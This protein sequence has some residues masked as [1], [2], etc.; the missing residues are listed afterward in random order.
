M[1]RSAIFAAGFAVIAIAGTGPPALAQADDPSFPTYDPAETC[2]G[3]R[4]SDA[5]RNMQ[6]LGRIMALSFWDKTTPAMHADCLATYPGHD[7]LP[8]S[9]CLNHYVKVSQPTACRDLSHE[10]VVYALND[11]LRYSQKP[12][13]VFDVI[14]PIVDG[15]ENGN[16]H[17]NCAATLVSTIGHIRW[18]LYTE[19]INGQIYYKGVSATMAR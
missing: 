15:P 14:G 11:I 4:A 5:C 3:E 8:L 10:E 12:G 7:Y 9:Y 18:V 1:R 2:S 19:V 13:H 17:H 16:G 6:K